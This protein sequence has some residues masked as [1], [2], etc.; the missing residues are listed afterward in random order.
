MHASVGRF[1]TD[2]ATTWARLW[3]EA[4][5]ALHG[6]EAT[7]PA[8]WLTRADNA[9]QAAKVPGW[10]VFSLFAG[11]NLFPFLL[12][13]LAL[14][15][16]SPL[17]ADPA[18]DAYKRGDFAIAT[19]E[20]AKVVTATPNDWTARHNLGLALAQQD[21]WAEA[22]AH[23]TS[24]FLLNPRAPAT[25]WDLALG[26]QHS[27]LAQP[28]LVE[29]SRGDGAYEIARLASPGQWQL[30]LIGAGLLFAAALALLLLQIYKRIGGWGAPVAILAG[31]AAM[32]LAAG[33][34]F[35]LH[36]YG[37][38]ANPSAV[39]VWEATTLRS[40]P[41]DADTSQ[42]TSPLS[43]GSIAVVEKVFPIGWTKL[44]FSGGQSGWVRTET[45]IPLYR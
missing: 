2:S 34:T 45:L 4:D 1:S 28:D 7:L 29:L 19:T 5:R 10:N 30:A 9:V 35:S 43:A 36:T 11:R 20:W 33:G 13:L 12:I 21:R 37:D 41:T 31:L 40:I 32:L 26:L 6:R 14:L 16:P 23:W 39:F 8:D 18:A 42:K 38:L 15:G 3:S 24:A 25:R 44:K 22:T 27:G 17:K